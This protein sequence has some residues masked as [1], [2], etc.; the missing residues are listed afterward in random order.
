VMDDAP[1][2]RAVEARALEVAFDGMEIEV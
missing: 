2:R 1:E